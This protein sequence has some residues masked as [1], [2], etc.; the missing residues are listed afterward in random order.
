MKQKV[1]V[2]VQYVREKQVIMAVKSP[3]LSDYYFQAAENL[4]IFV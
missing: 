2:Q 1:G 3:C 4:S